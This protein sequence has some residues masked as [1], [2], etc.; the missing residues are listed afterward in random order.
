MAKFP[1]KNHEVYYEVNGE[2]EP[3]VIL[4]GIM[5]STK[6]WEYL[7]EPVSKVCKLIRVDF[8][9]QGQ[10]DDYLDEPYTHDLQAELVLA[11][12][13]HLKI[14]KAYVLGLSYGGE[15]AI[16][17]A[18]KHQDRLLGLILS[19]TA[20]KT[21][22]W[23]RDIGRGWNGIGEHLDGETY[24]NI[25]IPVIYSP[26]FYQKHNDWMENRRKVLVPLFN[27][28]HFQGRMKRLVNSSEPL[29]EKANVHKI[30]VPTLIISSEYDFLTP[31]E[32]QMFLHQEIKNSHYV[33]IPNLGHG[34][35]YEDTKLFITLIIGFILSGE[36]S[37]L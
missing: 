30:S 16:K 3:L 13:D 22:E 18:L 37:I 14:E 21:N 11:L 17:F 35:M 36:T 9:D 20:A 1:F 32:E 4:N 5:M 6:S 28:P 7:V 26:S 15:V 27:D 33:F 31:K 25:A 10:T 24:Y 8:F 34:F 19:N 23:L 2:G 12:L 29:D